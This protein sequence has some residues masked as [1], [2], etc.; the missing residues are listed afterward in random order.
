M[1]VCLKALVCIYFYVNQI[2][3]HGKGLKANQPIWGKVHV[4][5]SYTIMSLASNAKGFRKTACLCTPCDQGSSWANQI[6]Q[7]QELPLLIRNVIVKRRSVSQKI[8]DWTQTDA[9]FPQWAGRGRIQPVHTLPLSPSLS[10]QTRQ[11]WLFYHVR[12]RIFRELQ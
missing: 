11:G 3:L 8:Q 9:R 12:R 2:N 6:A 7:I 10:K 5:Q 4:T 1:Q